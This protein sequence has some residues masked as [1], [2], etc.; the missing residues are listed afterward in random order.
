MTTCIL[1]GFS[2]RDLV[3]VLEK[4]IAD[5][6]ERWLV[7]CSTYLHYDSEDLHPSKVFEELVQYCDSENLYLVIGCDY[8]VHHIARGSTNCNDRGEAVV[9]FLNSLNLR[10]PKSRQ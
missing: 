10:D 7:V 9:K 5:G 8:N 2:C 4:Y 6:A 3:A 1:P